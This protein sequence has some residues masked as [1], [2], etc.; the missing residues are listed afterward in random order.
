M[1]IQSDLLCYGPIVKSEAGTIACTWLEQVVDA[2]VSARAE[3]LL[4][5]VVYDTRMQERCSYTLILM[6][7]TAVM[8]A[9]AIPLF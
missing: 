1:S 4:F 8:H 2:Y 7:P 6:K 9:H 5:Y 3:M